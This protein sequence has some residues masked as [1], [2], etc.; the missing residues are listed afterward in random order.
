MGQPFLG[1]VRIFGF[2]FA[3]LGW[4][5]CNGQIMSIAQNTAL[6]S[7]LG[8]TYGGNGI[9]TFALPD[10]QGRMPMNAGN[11]MTLGAIGGEEAHTLLLSEYRHDHPVTGQA[12]PRTSTISTAGVLASGDIYGIGP[13]TGALGPLAVGPSGCN[14]PH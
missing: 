11:G 3:P 9:Q 14:A 6:F 4:A 7:L 10:F 2:T 12:G 1:E 8:T 13:A 5:L